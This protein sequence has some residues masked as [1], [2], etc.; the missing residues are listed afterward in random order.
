VNALSRKQP[1]A[2]SSG[3][4]HVGCKGWVDPQRSRYGS[5]RSAARRPFS[6]RLRGKTGWIGRYSAQRQSRFLRTLPCPVVTIGQRRPK[7][8]RSN[9]RKKSS[10]PIDFPEDVHERLRIISGLAR[11]WARMWNSSTQWMFV[12]NSHF[13]TMPTD[14]Q[15]SLISWLSGSSGKGWRLSRLSLRGPRSGRFISEAAPR[16]RGAV[17]CFTLH[18]EECFGPSNE[19]GNFSCTPARSLVAKRHKVWALVPN[20]HV[21]QGGE[22][23]EARFVDGG[24]AT[25]NLMADQVRR[26]LGSALRALNE[27][28]AI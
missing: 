11:G 20:L 7:E 24:R 17:N 4:T 13:L 10:A 22:G 18:S 28:R 14:T 5:G 19:N 26:P 23:V 21:S 8:I 2:A 12:T 1:A 16:R 15:L 6:R 25:L 9:S 27:C 3:L